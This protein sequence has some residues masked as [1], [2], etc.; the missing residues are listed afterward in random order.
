MRELN[1]LIR[2]IFTAPGTT[3]VDYWLYLPGIALLRGTQRT[4]PT[5][6]P[7]LICTVTV[8][9]DHVGVYLYGCVSVNKFYANH[10]LASTLQRMDFALTTALTS[11]RLDDNGTETLVWDGSPCSYREGCS[12]K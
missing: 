11:R 12:L 8:A 3:F 7:S 4:K 1:K 2:G 5:V 9:G 10:Q 6:L